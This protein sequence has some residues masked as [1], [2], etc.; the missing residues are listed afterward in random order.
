MQPRSLTDEERRDAEDAA[1]LDAF[2]SQLVPHDETGSV[3]QSLIELAE[4]EGLVLS[5]G[6]YTSTTDTDG[7]FVRH[8]MNFPVKGGAHSVPRFI[9]AALSKHKALALETAQ[10]KRQRGLP[11]D[12]E[13]RVQ[14]ILLTRLPPGPAER[15]VTGAAR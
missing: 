3:L 14:F 10:F 4:V 9:L 15:S 2:E 7:Q 5:R 1:R 8:R 12:M 13:A 11:Q 6:D